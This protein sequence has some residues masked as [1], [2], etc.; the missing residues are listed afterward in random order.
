MPMWNFAVKPNM[1]IKAQQLSLYKTR[2]TI[3][4]H[5]A[6]FSLIMV[7]IIT[8]LKT[9]TS[10]PKPWNMAFWTLHWNIALLQ[11]TEMT[12]GASMCR[13]LALLC[14]NMHFNVTTDFIFFFTCFHSVLCNLIP[15]S[16]ISMSSLWP[17]SEI[18]TGVNKWIN[19]TKKKMICLGLPP[20]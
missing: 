15:T 20:N 9:W 4:S 11:D 17:L 1:H 2:S 6:Q 16:T 8:H 19:K 18:L 13:S 14:W 5:K 10:F 12:L 7:E 3:Y